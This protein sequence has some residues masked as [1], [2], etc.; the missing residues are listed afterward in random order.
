MVNH[1]GSSTILE[2]GT[3]FGITT[4]YLAAAN[5]NGFVIT[6][7]GAPEIAKQAERHFQHIPKT[8]VLP[9]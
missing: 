5:Q 9:E 3:S 4:S 8:A 1:F 7:E 2:L 6:M